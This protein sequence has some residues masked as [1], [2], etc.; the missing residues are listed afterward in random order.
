MKCFSSSRDRSSSPV[1][2]G[3]RDRSSRSP[4]KE[5]NDDKKEENKSDNDKSINEKID[6]DEND[7]SHSSPAAGDAEMKNNDED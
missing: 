4:S 6:H 7:E 2:K 3:R 1:E 5:D